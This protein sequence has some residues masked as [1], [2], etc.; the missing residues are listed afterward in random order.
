MMSINW[1]SWFFT[2]DDLFLNWL[3]GV[4][5]QL[6]YKAN[7]IKKYIELEVLKYIKQ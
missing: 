2:T 4:L 3:N 6:L 7:D 1:L 5:V